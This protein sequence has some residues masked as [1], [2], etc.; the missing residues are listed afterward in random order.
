M[1]QRDSNSTQRSWG[2]ASSRK[3]FTLVELLVVIGIIALLV[4]MLLPALTKP[5]SLVAGRRV[6]RTCGSAPSVRALRLENKDAVPLRHR[7]ASK[8]FNSMVYSA[9]T[10][11]GCSFGCFVSK[12]HP[13]AGIP[14]LPVGGKPQVHVQH[15]GQPLAGAGR[16]ADANVQTGYGARPEILLP[17][18]LSNPPLGFVM[19]R[20]TRFKNK[21]IF[22][23][24][25][26]ARR[27]SSPASG[28]GER[29]LW[30]WRREVGAAPGVRPAESQVER[31]RGRRAEPRAERDAHCDLDGVRCAVI[32]ARE[33]G[34]I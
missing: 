26:A 33:K 3:A 9:T 24:L 16:D 25:T 27:G 2:F 5:G 22:A 6:S 8:Q 1:R 10:G 19:P 11:A 32:P 14:V 31:A 28:R 15:R 30:A 29:A 17:D 4:G 18:D 7:S 12:V 13:H 21:A 20:L 34:S 23:D